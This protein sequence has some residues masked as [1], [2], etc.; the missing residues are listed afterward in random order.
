[1]DFYGIVCEFNPFHNGHKY[2]IEQTRE[3]TGTDA[4]VCVMSGSFVQRGDVAVFDK[5]QRAEMAVK[6]GADLVVELPVSSVL[7]SA[8]KFADG[9]VSILSSLGAKGLA[10]GAECERLELLKEIAN[11]R[12]NESEEYKKVLKD[13]LDAGKGYPAACEEAIKACI[14]DVDS[15]AFGPNSTLAVSYIKAAIDKGNNLD[16]CAVKR[17]GDYHSTDLS[18]RYPSATAIRENLLKEGRS[19]V[20]DIKRLETLILGKFRS[21]SE[22]EIGDICSMED[23]LALRMIK[24]AGE[25]T[26][27]EEFIAK[28]VTKRY[29]AHRIRRVMLCTLLGIKEYETP[30]YARVLA[31]NEKGAGILK[32][33]K[34]RDIEIIT[35]INKN[36]IPDMLRKDIL[37]TDIAALCVGGKA[38]MDFTKSPVVL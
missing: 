23:G 4:I 34:E 30:R 31:L 16:F 8:D 29:T 1:V 12:A 21:S 32:Q 22:K 19:D 9:A 28:C 24:A 36:N 18:V 25:V 15:D 27:L 5:W 14:K 35:K 33:A 38:G 10:F 2:L 20:Y 17:I 26:T 3:K 11:V 37:S 13:A 6:N 7:Q